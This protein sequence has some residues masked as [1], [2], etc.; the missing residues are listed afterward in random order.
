MASVTILMLLLLL[1]VLSIY[2]SI[3]RFRAAVFSV[4][5]LLH[6][7]NAVGE[8][9]ARSFSKLGIKPIGKI[10]HLLTGPCW[11]NYQSEAFYFLLANN[12]IM[13]TPN[14]KYYIAAAKLA[15]F[16]ASLRKLTF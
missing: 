9:N 14:N 3:K 12:V 11:R 1:A 4:I 13:A 16:Q 7:K 10:G 8:A 2:F 5:E 6:K 15:A